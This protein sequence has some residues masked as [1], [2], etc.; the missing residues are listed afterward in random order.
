[1]NDFRMNLRDRQAEDAV[2][3]GL[4]ISGGEFLSTLI[5]PPLEFQAEMLWSEC[6]QELFS[7]MLDLH[8]QGI[9]IDYVTL[10]SVTNHE[11]DDHLMGLIANTPTAM[12]IPHYASIVRQYWER[13]SVTDIATNLVRQVNS[14]DA[15]LPGAMSSLAALKLKDKGREM[16]AAEA[17]ISMKSQNYRGTTTGFPLLDYHTG[18]FVPTHFWVVDGFTSSG[19]TT[20]ALNLASHAL[21]SGLPVLYFS[22][23][24]SIEELIRRLIAMRSNVDSRTVTA[25]TS[26]MSSRADIDEAENYYSTAPLIM[27]DDIYNIEAIDHAVE[28]H[29]RRQPGGVVILDYLQNLY[30]MD[31]FATMSGAATATQLLAKRTGT[32]AIAISQIS[33]TE[34]QK[35]DIG[36]YYS[37]KGS[38]AIR[39]AADKV[40]R[41][42]RD[43]DSEELKV[44]ILK[45]RQGPAGGSMQ[46]YFNL[47][48]G[49]ITQLDREL[50]NI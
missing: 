48:T 27:F 12:H 5:S 25:E 47:K 33:N 42:K 22:L 9:A 39:D 40:V 13:R 3:G 44:F 49:N 46:L 24:Q 43:R 37:Q 11:H 7:A 21:K 14:G 18:G 4:L 45:N 15:D 41:L 8:S 1:M 6:N 26:H 38:G 20:F 36:Q 35:P 2:I 29:T 32:T 19:K 28:K 16:T 30:W 10:A 31:M 17:I 23:E 50:L 34:A